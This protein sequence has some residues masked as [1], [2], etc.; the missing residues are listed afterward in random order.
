MYSR[1]Q[2]GKW[3]ICELGTHPSD[4]PTADAAATSPDASAAH[5]LMF[6]WEHH[7]QKKASQPLPPSLYTNGGSHLH[8]DPHLTFLKLGKRQYFEDAT[9]TMGDRHVGSG[10][11]IVKRGRS[12]DVVSSTSPSS[13][14]V[15]P[16][17]VPRCQVEGCHVV[18]VNAKDYHKRHKVC[19][20]H[21]KAPKVVVLG[22]EQRFCQQCSRFHAVSEFDDT[23]R[24]CRRR[25]AGHNERRRKTSHDSTSRNP[26]QDSDLMDGR[27]PYLSTTGRA[28]SLLSSSKNI[29]PW[30]SPSNNLSSRSS[31]ALLEL[32]AENRAAILARQLIMDRDWFSGAP[33]P[34]HHHAFSEPPGL[35]QF[36]QGSTQVTLDLMQAPSSTF[37][38][39][40]VRGNSK[41][42]EEECCDLWNSLE[43]AHVV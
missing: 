1:G 31:A 12:Y 21:S 41:E 7:Y 8:P 39:F 28:L 4:H 5:A 22:L 17:S 30:V 29:H 27:L 36:H 25:L 33:V 10:F 23:K 32:I 24:S 20:M 34:N 6:D 14:A 11:S 37:G 26:S 43:A 35:D 15:S 3:D 38:F 9:T 40:S 42:E 18:L 19:E 16:A 13:P 2:N